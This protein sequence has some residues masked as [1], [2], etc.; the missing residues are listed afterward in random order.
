MSNSRSWKLILAGA[1]LA[2]VIPAAAWSAKPVAY[3]YGAHCN[4]KKICK[5]LIYTNAK[6]SRIISVQLVGACKDASS[7][8]FTELKK[9]GKINSKHKFKLELTTGSSD[10]NTAENG[11]LTMTGK[12]SKK[13]K[14][15]GKWSIDKV[16]PGC[17]NLKTGKFSL[18]YKGPIF[19]G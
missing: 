11:K 6:S 15:T 10:G 19:G 12:L 2:L 16:V 13:K 7:S 18:K 17:A 5:Q 8:I 14:I 3:N 1:L 4:S 9:P